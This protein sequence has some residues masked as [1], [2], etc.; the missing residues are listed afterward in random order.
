VRLLVTGAGLVG[1]ALS[2]RLAADGHHVTLFDIASGRDDLPGRYVQADVRDAAAVK[3]AVHAAE[4][5]FHTAAL[6]TPHFATFSNQDFMDVNVT[7]TYNVLEAATACDVRVVHCSTLGVLGFRARPDQGVRPVTI[8]DDDIDQ[9]RHPAELYGLTKT[10]N[11]NTIEYFH[12]NFGLDVV[13]LRYGAIWELVRQ[14]FRD[15][16]AAVASGNIVTALDDV[17]ESQV[18]AMFHA[19]PL[20]RLTYTVVARP[21]V[22][23]HDLDA[24]SGDVRAAAA[25][26]YPDLASVLPDPM[27]SPLFFFD[28]NRTERDLGMTITGRA[29][30]F[31]REAVCEF[32]RPALDV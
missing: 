31:L 5:V 10:L 11:E 18:A 17:V 32:D 23:E 7:G 25:A 27:S 6:H 1:T 2:R 26:K 28:L 22:D 21:V 12:A 15:H 3:A 14:I 13:A 9:R 4:G 16:L 8:D 29:E 20:P 24:A 19:G 30:E